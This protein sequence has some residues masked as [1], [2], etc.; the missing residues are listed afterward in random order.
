[1]GACFASIVT[2]EK[3]VRSVKLYKWQTVP[4]VAHMK[5]FRS[6][7]APWTCQAC[8]ASWTCTFDADST[9]GTHSSQRIPT[10]EL[11]LDDFSLVEQEDDPVLWNGCPVEIVAGGGDRVLQEWV[12]DPTSQMRRYSG[13]LFECDACTAQWVCK[14]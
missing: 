2:S 10:V 3:E 1:M 5:K 9:R 12:V 7:T 11:V 6:P 8:L 13:P 14:C 4:L